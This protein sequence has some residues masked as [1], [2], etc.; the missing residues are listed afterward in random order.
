MMSGTVT[1]RIFST[2]HAASVSMAKAAVAATHA[3]DP[4]VIPFMI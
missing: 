2:E 4:F 3:R 1:S